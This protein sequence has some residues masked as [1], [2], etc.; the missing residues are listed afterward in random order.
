SPVDAARRWIVVR[1]QPRGEVSA[2]LRKRVPVRPRPVDL[3][4]GDRLGDGGAGL[5]RVRPACNADRTVIDPPAVNCPKATWPRPDCKSRR[6]CSVLAHLPTVA[7]D[8]SAINRL[9]LSNYR[10]SADGLVIATYR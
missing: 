7:T 10:T 9:F 4:D 5:R 6:L 3:V 8:D 1:A 2:V